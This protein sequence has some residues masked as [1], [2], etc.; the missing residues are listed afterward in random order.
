MK[1]IDNAIERYLTTSG[2]NR[3]NLRA[4]LFDMDGVLYDSMPNHA[5]AWVT[6]MQ[7]HGIK[8][9]EEESYLHEGRTGV[10]TLDILA[11]RDGISLTEDEK[12]ALYKEKAEMFEK[13]ERAEPIKGAPE[14]LRKVCNSGI[15]AMLVTG[16]GQP[17]LIESLQADFPNAFARERMVT[18]FDVKHGKPDPEPYLMA[19]RKGCLQPNEAIVVENAPLGIQAAKAAELFTVA[20]N[21]GPLS[22]STL[23]SAGA[24]LLLPSVEVLSYIWETLLQSINKISLNYERERLYQQECRTF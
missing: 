8:M 24:D 2:N 16:S 11:S 5:T 4:V 23:L 14:L 3:M 17:S 22:D 1:E 13:M 15:F 12:I 9:T 10:G 20:V 18:S 6:T 21:T 19:L 7:R